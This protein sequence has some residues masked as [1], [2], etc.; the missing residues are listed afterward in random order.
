V[1][2]VSTDPMLQPT[3]LTSGVGGGL[4]DIEQ[5]PALIRAAHFV[6]CDDA[7]WL[8]RTQSAQVPCEPKTSLSA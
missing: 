8:E 4:L 7:R 2:T 6:N 5:L 3:T 1:T